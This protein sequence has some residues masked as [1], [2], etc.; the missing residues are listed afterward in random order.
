MDNNKIRL[1]RYAY[2]FC[3]SILFIFNIQA[4]SDRIQ[5]LIDSLDAVRPFPS[6]VEA[7]NIFERINRM[8]V[9]DGDR[10]NELYSKIFIGYFNDILGNKLES[11]EATEAA[12]Q[13]AHDTTGLTTEN[14]I[15][16]YQWMQ[17]LV[18]E[19]GNLNDAIEINK[20]YVE[21]EL[22]NGADDVQIGISYLELGAGYRTL[23]DF[24]NAKLYATN[25]FNLF[26]NAPDSLFKF[27]VDKKLRL[28]RS[29]QIRGL[30]HKDNKNYDQAISDY[31][32][33]LGYLK[34]S[35]QYDTSEGIMS[36][37][38]CYARM[39]DVFLLQDDLDNTKSIIKKLA[40][41]TKKESYDKYRYFELTSLLSLKQRNLTSTAF[42][43]QKAIDLA[44]IELKDSKEYP[45]IAKL[46]MIYGDYYLAKDSI[47][48]ALNKYQQGLKYFDPNLDNQLINNPKAS[49]ISEVLALQLLEKKASCLWTLFKLSNDQSMLSASISTYNSAIELID[50]M[51]SDF[52]GEGSKYKVAEMASSIFQEAL[53]A[54][55]DYYQLSPQE[56]TLNSIFR[57]IEKNK[58]EILFQNISNKYNLLASTLPKEFIDKGIELNYN[59]SYYSKLLSEEN[60]KTDR[61][62]NLIEKY[63]NKLFKLNENYTFHEQRIKDMYPEFY[64][65][66]NEITN[67]NSASDLKKALK[68]NQIIIEYFRTEND[69]YTVSIS[70]TKIK[71]KRNSMKEIEL[72]IEKYFN[73]ISNP[74][75]AKNNNHTEM[76]SL[77]YA[78]AKYLLL[79]DEN[80]HY[81]LEKIIII[82]DGI[83]NRIPLETLIIDENGKMLIEQCN[84]TYN[85]SSNQ[86]FENIES[87]RLENPNVLCLTPTFEGIP[88]AQRTCN[89]SILG[90][91]P[92]VKEE[93]NFLKANFEG[94][95]FNVNSANLTN[96]KENFA[97]H[98]IIHLATHACLNNKDPMLSQIYFSD[99]SMTNY[100]I[101]NLN[102]RP[103]LVVLSACNTA[104]GRIQDGEGVIGLSRGFFEAGV[105]GMQ[106]SLW[107]IDDLSSSKVVT[108]M[109]HYLKQEK[110]KSEALRLSKLDYLKNADKLQSHPYYWAA[111]IH[112]GNDNP[113][114]FSSNAKLIKILSILVIFILVIGFVYNLMRSKQQS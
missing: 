106:S 103:E 4:Q 76:Q 75:S 35:K 84:V 41:L 83:I 49:L 80:Y 27:E 81:D 71:V 54:N 61:N 31:S 30:V 90:N 47:S 50:K 72:I 46:Q 68:Q 60:I 107:S 33:S 5:A 16:A 101:Q 113:I 7:L 12:Y 57:I 77:S 18:R 24:E 67:E 97:N 100:D 32:N 55:Y 85:Y 6:S 23:G 91:L 48:K 52:I 58:A 69:L 45:E 112:I 21:L 70:S 93:F 10:N 108:G 111:I 78:L 14:I 74:P 29:L 43:I 65:F 66:K 17:N 40:P 95:F 59:I 3:I 28:F 39:A 110:P 92:Y 34:K 22:K 1:N 8:S 114:S 79:E 53:K 105:K 36:R 82:P 64:K 88:S 104:S 89:A 11:D 26:Q 25:A 13:L 42:D 2:V 44:I 86:F 73:Y 102:S 96:L 63:E 38:D 15:L 99:G 56:S 62:Q 20:K 37:I 19:R 9:Q 51:K 98:Q 94:R 109:Y 87:K